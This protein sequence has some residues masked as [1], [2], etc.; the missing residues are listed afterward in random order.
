MRSENVSI[1]AQEST[2][3]LYNRDENDIISYGDY[4]DKNKALE[5]NRSLESLLDS[6]NTG[7]Q[8]CTLEQEISFLPGK[9]DKPKREFE[10]TSQNSQIFA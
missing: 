6:Q 10:I 7:N 4:E 3:G 1:K 8:V 5:L 9:P 2:P